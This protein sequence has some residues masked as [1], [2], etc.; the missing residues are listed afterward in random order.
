LGGNQIIIL[1]THIRVKSVLDEANCDSHFVIGF[2]KMG[3]RYWCK[4][5]FVL[6]SG[7][8]S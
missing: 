3:L 4:R 2:V 1:D 8:I 6:G 5:D 7:K